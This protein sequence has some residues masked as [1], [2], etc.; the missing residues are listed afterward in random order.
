MPVFVCFWLYCES[1][2]LSCS[3]FEQPRVTERTET[4]ACSQTR[5]CA[6]GKTKVFCGR[7]RQVR[8]YI[9]IYAFSRRFYPK[10][11]TLHSSYSL[12]ALAFPG[13]RTHD[14]GVA[15]AMLYHLSY[16]KAMT[17]IDQFRV[18]VT[19]TSLA[20]ARALWWQKHTVTSGVKREK[21]TE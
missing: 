1:L 20:A 18:D 15:S 13:N 7:G 9:Y 14:L 4:T 3:V 8:H 2:F 16:R 19:V 21:S 17:T 11:L 12:S 5:P 6:Q 10:R